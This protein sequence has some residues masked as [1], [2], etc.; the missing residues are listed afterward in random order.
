MRCKHVPTQ[1]RKQYEQRLLQEE[2]R[3][4]AAVAENEKEPQV[5]LY[6]STRINKQA[7]Q[8]KSCKT[9][10][11]LQAFIQDDLYF[12]GRDDSPCLVR[13]L[14]EILRLERQSQK[15]DT[16]RMPWKGKEKF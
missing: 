6:E 14:L 4:K 13:V 8:G 3:K 15:R 5:S 2:H 12:F 16:S 10:K 9:R 1:E 11:K 7:R